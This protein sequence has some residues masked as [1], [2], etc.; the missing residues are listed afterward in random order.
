M[1]ISP[2]IIIALILKISSLITFI[3]S[4]KYINVYISPAAINC[5]ILPNKI[6]CAPKLDCREKICSGSIIHCSVAFKFR[7]TNRCTH[8]LEGFIII[9]KFHYF[10]SFRYNTFSI[11]IYIFTMFLNLM[12][13]LLQF[14]EK[15]N[16]NQV[17]N[18]HKSEG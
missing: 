5:R 8:S 17:G 15:I 9:K 4:N 18:C 16:F 12:K 7:S 14:Q 1:S 13:Y 11:K 3:I 10:F 2:K 6:S